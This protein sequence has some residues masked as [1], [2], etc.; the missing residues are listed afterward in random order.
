MIDFDSLPSDRFKWPFN[1]MDLGEVVK[2]ELD[3][4]AILKAQKAAASYSYLTGK[5]FQTKTSNGKLYVKRVK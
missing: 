1:K 4:D 5:K 2:L 3:R